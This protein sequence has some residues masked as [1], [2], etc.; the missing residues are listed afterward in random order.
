T[1]ELNK[2]LDLTT[3]SGRPVVQ[4]KQVFK[5]YFNDFGDNSINLLVAFWVLVEEKINFVYKVKETIYSTLQRNNI[6]IP[7][8]QHD[9]YI[10]RLPS[11]E[12]PQPQAK[13]NKKSKLTI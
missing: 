11:L 10:R 6:E 8:P 13:G 9:V 4:K 1:K 12:K 2:L 5:V 7:F 3:S